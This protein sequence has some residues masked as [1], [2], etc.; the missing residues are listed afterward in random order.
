MSQRQLQA[1]EIQSLLNHLEFGIGNGYIERR[2]VYLEIEGYAIRIK[3]YPTD[4]IRPSLTA[5]KGLFDLLMTIFPL[6]RDSAELSDIELELRPQN[7]ANKFTAKT[8]KRGQIWFRE[9]PAGEN[10]RIQ[11]K[12]PLVV[13]PLFWIKAFFHQLLKNVSAYGTLIPQW[14]GSKALA[15][16]V[17]L[18][19]PAVLVLAVSLTFVFWPSE[20]KI[21]TTFQTIYANKTDEMAEE[22]RDVQFSWEAADDANVFAFSQGA[23]A[24][25]EAAKA[26]GA[27]LWTARES[28]L[29]TRDI[30]L[31]TPLLPP[32]PED[33]WLKTDWAAY[34][35]LGRW[36]L[37]LWTASEFPDEMAK[38]FWDEQRAIFDD[39]NATFEARLAT[40]NEAKKVRHQ[41][42]S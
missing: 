24:S 18:A 1:N 35:D 37:L 25:A 22:L 27:G 31:P 33:S 12:T 26:F 11:V 30:T 42:N 39:F 4:K 5:K 15:W 6:E 16:K 7:T 3:P 41:L 19:V 2:G 17:S 21:D 9:V 36:T 40:D 29:E 28:L 32:T 8:N 14:I 10:Y 20:N 23:S 38:S 13:K 34:F